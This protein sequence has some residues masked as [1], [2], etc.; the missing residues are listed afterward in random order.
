M[1]IFLAGLR[2]VDSEILNAARI[3]GAGMLLVYRSIVIPILRPVFLTVTIIL[4]FQAIRSFDLVVA[5]TGGGPGYSS[6]LPTNYMYQMAFGRNRMG[7]SAASAMMIFMTVAAVMVPY[8]YSEMR[9]EA[10]HDR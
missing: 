3:D 1:A 2:G 4:T 7:L 10:R 8:V 6:D 5:L 9:R